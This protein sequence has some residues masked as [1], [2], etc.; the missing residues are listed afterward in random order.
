MNYS[1]PK[2]QRIYFSAPYPLKILF[3]SIY[4]LKQRNERYGNHFNYYLD[5][6]KNSEYKDNQTLLRELEFEKEK[7][8]EFALNNSS[9]YKNVYK[10]I[11]NFKEFQILTKNDLRNHKNSII[12]ESLLSSSRMVHTS[13]TTGSAL[14]FPI[15][16]ECFQRE[17]AFRAMHYYWAGIDVLKKPRIATFSGHPVADPTRNKA[18]F[19]VYDFVNNW[20]LF[21]SYHINEESEREYIKKIIEFDPIAFHGYPSTI[22]LIALAHK[23]Y[24]RKLRSLKAIFTASETL[25]DFQRN[26][27]ED[28]FQTKV[29]NWYGNTEMC[30]NIVECD[31]GRMHLKL[32]HSYVEILDENNQPVKPGERGRL[33]CTAIGNKAFPLIRYDIGDI[34]QLSKVE[35]CECG[36]GGLIIDFVEG[37]KEDYIITKDGKKIGRLDHLFK[38]TLG[39]K[40]AQIVQTEVGRIIIKI[41]PADSFS[42]KDLNLLK[43][44]IYV[45]FGNKID[46]EIEKVNHISRGANGKFRFVVSEIKNNIIIN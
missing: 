27:I 45:R 29:Y 21:S 9:Y 35:K 11:K 25:Y 4:G 23:K 39:I 43:N 37:R 14:V 36:R 38:D 10:G 33:V 12:V 6:L 46:Y 13:G 16:K 40:E 24:G 15:T 18:P 20:L 31:K 7:F 1:N 44:E 22:Y 5:L 32:E 42:D 19:W 2:F 34:A 30:A 26:M 3:S 28:V 8:I 41:V 17:Y